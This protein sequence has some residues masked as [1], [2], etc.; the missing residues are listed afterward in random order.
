MS[1]NSSMSTYEI[2]E[3]L[4]T[5]GFEIP[6]DHGIV[7][8]GGGYG[9]FGASFETIDEIIITDSNKK[10]IHKIWIC[11]SCNRPFSSLQSTQQTGGCCSDKCLI[12]KETLFGKTRISDMNCDICERTNFIG[13]NSFVLNK[14]DQLQLICKSCRENETNYKTVLTDPFED[15]EDD[16]D[17]DYNDRDDDTPY[18]RTLK[19]DYNDHYGN[20]DYY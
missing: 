19:S 9:G 2:V 10:V 11:Y 7:K 5:L 12:Y 14:N 20:M 8:T 16:Y 17:Y 13:N 3:K 6:D 4:K 1:I 15:D 18:W